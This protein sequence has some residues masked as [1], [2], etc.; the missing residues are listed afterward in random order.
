MLR[1][2]GW[3]SSREP[4]SFDEVEVQPAS[5]LSRGLPRWNRDVRGNSAF[6][7]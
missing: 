3:V 1:E 7:F 6:R 2:F 5:A 4:R